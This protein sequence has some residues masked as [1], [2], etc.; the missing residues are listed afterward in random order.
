[1]QEL[2]SAATFQAYCF[3]SDRSL[4]FLYHHTQSHLILEARTFLIGCA[5]P[6]YFLQASGVEDEMVSERQVK[7]ETVFCNII[8]SL[9]LVSITRAKEE[10]GNTLLF[11]VLCTGCDSLFIS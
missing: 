1:M 10:Q 9:I 7:H 6:L 8:Y 5:G 2:S 3:S 11:T 4:L